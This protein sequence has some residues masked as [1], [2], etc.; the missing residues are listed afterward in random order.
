MTFSI[1]DLKHNNA[2]HYAGCRILSIVMLSVFM[3]RVVLLNVVM[4]NVVMLS[5]VVPRKGLAIYNGAEVHFTTKISV[6]TY[7][8]VF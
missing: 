1:N 5:A 7:K 4:L 2:R 6:I 8:N 3:L